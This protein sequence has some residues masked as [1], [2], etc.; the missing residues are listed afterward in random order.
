[1][2]LGATS[3]LSA[4]L[5]AGVQ[6]TQKSVSDSTWIKS[7]ARH[8]RFIVFTES[9]QTGDP[10][11]QTSGHATVRGIAGTV[12][13]TEG[14]PMLH[15]GFIKVDCDR[16]SVTIGTR[17]FQVTIPDGGSAL[18]ESFPAIR[19]FRVASLTAPANDAVSVRYKQARLPVRLSAGEMVST[20]GDHPTSTQKFDAKV[21]S[22]LVPEDQPL[23][24]G[25][26]ASS[27]P[28][29]INA[30]Q[31][32]QFKC[33]SS[34]AVAIREGECLISTGSNLSVLGPTA[35]AV[36]KKNALID[37]EA[38]TGDFRVKSLSGPGHVTVQE[39]EQTLPL[40]PG[41]EIFIAKR[42]VED[43]D[44]TP[45]DG[46]GRRKFENLTL[47]DGTKAI[48]SDFSIPSFMTAAEHAQA[49]RRSSDP[50]DHDVSERILK[51]AAA[52][53]AL[54]MTKGMYT[55]VPRQPR[56]IRRESGPSA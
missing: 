44:K 43:S 54:T 55:A 40:H 11:V 21:F 46:V 25:A 12:M 30:I 39:G 34:G 22:A 37:V 3:A 41:Q 38:Y 48:M 35:Q 45:P 9:G 2:G 27:Q 32:T 8:A 6:K 47:K 20:E 24:D 42:V 31:A 50:H 52:V 56:K 33:M 4:E 18:I 1:M 36:A 5:R 19:S 53:Q 51:T 13:S 49:I 16:G 26:D 29:R 14:M 15:N 23:L 10:I 7:S 17:A 28:S